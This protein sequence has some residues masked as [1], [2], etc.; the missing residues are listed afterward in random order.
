MFAKK[1]KKTCYLGIKKKLT[2]RDALMFYFFLNWNKIKISF[3]VESTTFSN[4]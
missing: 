2:K 1:K 4:F 3:E